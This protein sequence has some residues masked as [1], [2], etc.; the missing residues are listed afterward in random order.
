MQLSSDKLSELKQELLSLIPKE[1]ITINKRNDKTLSEDSLE[2]K[3]QF[4][5]KYFNNKKG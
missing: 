4:T 2:Y 5:N 1:I 3:K